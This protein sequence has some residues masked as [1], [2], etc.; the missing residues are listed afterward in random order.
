MRLAFAS[1]LVAAPFAVCAQQAQPDETHY[2]NVSG[3]TAAEVRA[4]MN[5]SRPS[6]SDGQRHDAV[7]NW[8]IRW[9]YRTTAARNRCDL[10]SFS[11]VEEVTETMPKWLDEPSAPPDLAARWH[12]FIATLTTHEAGHVAIA[13]EA[14]EAIRKAGRRLTSDANCADLKRAID[15]AGNG[16]LAEYKEKD[17]KYDADTQHG[18]TQG[19]KFP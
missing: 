17:K 8:T 18:R 2:Y 5:A 13:S 11:V 6:T 7:T 15:N 9:Q 19:V 10:T 14:L 3:T 12:T 1:A 4:S 16:L